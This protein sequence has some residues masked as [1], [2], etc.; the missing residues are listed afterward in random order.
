MTIPRSKTCWASALLF[1]I[2]ASASL[3]QV[4]A[5]V[6]PKTTASKP[7]TFHWETGPGWFGE[8]IKL[9]PS[10]SP[11]MSWKG[12]EEI[13]FAPGMFKADRPDFFSYALVFSLEPEA[14]VSLAGLSKQILLYYQGLSSRV[15]AGKG[16]KVDVSKF[17]IDLKPAKDLS[18]SAPKQA[19]SPAAYLA[20]LKWIEPFATGKPQDLHLEIHAWKDKNR[21]RTYLFFCASPQSSDAP[22][23][24]TLRKIRAAFVAK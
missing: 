20:T 8:R 7:E 16:R 1:L 19:K 21:K 24:K 10:F 11:T 12:I 9:P 13:R 23:R 17:T 15:S 18:G 2:G 22:I 5:E 6:A 3:A 4:N 14:D